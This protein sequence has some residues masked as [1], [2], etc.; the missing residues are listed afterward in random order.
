[1]L[2][3]TAELPKMVGTIPTN[4]VYDHLTQCSRRSP[5]SYRPAPLPAGR[6][7][8]SFS[9]SIPPSFALSI[10]L[11]TINTRANWLCSGDFLLPRDLPAAHSLATGHC[12]RA[13]VLPP[14]ASRLTLHA[15][16]AGS[17]HAQTLPAGYC[18]TPTAELTKTERDPI[19]TNGPSI[20]SMSPDQAIPPGKSN[21]FYKFTADLPL[22]ILS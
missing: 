8:A 20:F 13:T 5:L 10:N 14:H 19:S 4:I 3:I 9:R 12:S 18:L 7:L 6:K 17:R 22:T 2:R 1:M 11:Q 21:R 15:S 16:P